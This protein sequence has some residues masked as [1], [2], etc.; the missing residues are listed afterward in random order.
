[1]KTNLKTF[2]RLLFSLIILV[3]FVFIGGC[4]QS[5]KNGESSK[6]LTA[7][8][9]FAIAK[10]EA[11]DWSS[12]VVFVDLS[13][14]RG[15]SAV[16]GQSARWDFVFNSKKMD[17]KLEVRINRSKVLQ[18]VDGI[19]VEKDAITDGWIDSPEVMDIAL[20][21]CEDKP[22]DNYWLGM[23]VMRGV[24]TWSVNCEYEESGNSWIEVN[25]LTGGYIKNR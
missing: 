21:Y 14:F 5:Q 12:D 23:A 7:R 10:D 11:K 8:E 4:E 25:A 19:Y 20:E 18:A 1:M 13:N 3:G 2:E 15:T 17:K 22:I 9:A 6:Q 24:L 16:N